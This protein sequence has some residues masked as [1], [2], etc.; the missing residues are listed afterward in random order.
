MKFCIRSFL[1]FLLVCGWVL[2]ARADM[3]FPARLE[4][5]ESQPGLFDVRFNLPV[6]N[7]A[8]IKATPVLPSVCVATAPP[9]ETFTATRY[10]AAWQVSCPAE[11]LP[12]QTVG[13][14][15]LLGSQIDV[16]LSIKTLDGRQ[17]SAVLKPA[18]ARYVIPRPPSLLQLTGKALVDGMRGSF[19]RIDLYLLI[20]LIV[21]FGRRRREG[22]IALMA[23][24][25]TYAVAQ[26]FARGNLLLLPAGLPTVLILLLSVYFANRLANGGDIGQ[27]QRLSAW[28]AGGFIGALYGGAL[29]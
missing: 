21:L 7:Q 25:I 28:V 29:Q 17:Y 6:Q 26:A 19:G 20:W 15:G 4:L 22:L 18:R 14:D 2:P 24:G 5:V 10:M 27:K 13:V 8:R 3:V 9:E 12:G 11:A 1:L 23:G 16:L